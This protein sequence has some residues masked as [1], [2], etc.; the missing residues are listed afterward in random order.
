MQGQLGA[1]NGQDPNQVGFGQNPALN[2]I[3]NQLRNQNNAFGSQTNGQSGFNN[4]GQTGSNPSSGF[5]TSNGSGFN[6]PASTS[7]FGTP[8]QTSQMSNSTMGGGG[9]AGVASNQNGVGIKRYNDRKKYK[10]WEFVFD[11]RKPKTKP[12]TG[13]TGTPPN[14]LNPSN[15]SGTST[16]GFGSGST[17]GFSSTPGTPTAPSTT[18]R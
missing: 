7:G 16:S 10:E 9:I 14:G 4:G 12:T 6:N 2:A 3:N 18:T 1:Q 11:Y 15:P 5:G 17:S 13:V 8:V